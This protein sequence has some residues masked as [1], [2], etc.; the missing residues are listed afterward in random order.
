MGRKIILVGRIL[1]LAAFRENAELNF[2]G[3]AIN[4]GK[5]GIV[6]IGVESDKGNGLVKA[7]LC[8]GACHRR[9][10]YTWS[11]ANYK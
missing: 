10:T 3:F 2:G 7:I 5:V 1:K 8:Q 4:A 9:L 11:V 6:A